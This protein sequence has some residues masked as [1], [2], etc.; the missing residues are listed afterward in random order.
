[1]LKERKKK[2]FTLNI[3]IESQQNTHHTLRAYEEGGD[4]S[5]YI[6]RE[7]REPRRDL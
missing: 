4:V 2:Q 5:R 1:M 6:G 7:P 3:S